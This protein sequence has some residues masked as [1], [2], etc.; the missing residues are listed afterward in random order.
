MIKIQTL[1]SLNKVV[2]AAWVLIPLSKPQPTNFLSPQLPK[3]LT[4]PPRQTESPDN[5]SMLHMFKNNTYTDFGAVS[6]Y[7]LIPGYVMQVIK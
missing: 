6:K 1:F 2:V 4:G 5:S 3:N 7:V